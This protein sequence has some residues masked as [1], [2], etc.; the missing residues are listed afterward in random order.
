[1]SNLNLILQKR[2]NKEFMKALEILIEEHDSILKMI[3][4][5]QKLLVNADKNTVIN[6]GHIEDIIDFIK[7]FADKYHHMKEEDVLFREMEGYGMPRDGGPI[8]VMLME[9][10][11]GRRYV[12]NAAEA[13]KDYKNG[14]S[15]SMLVLKNNLLNYC[16]LLINHIYKENHILYPMA[17]KMLPE[18][19]LNNMGTTFEKTN[20]STVNNEYFD[21]Y[22]KMVEEMNLIYK[23]EV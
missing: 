19:C 5:T 10:E 2:I 23:T 11:E 15:D 3:E 17:E 12:K 8:G 7:N 18:E 22:L 1:M 20:Y 13:I 9:H 14:K 4:I 16:E 6:I 21:K